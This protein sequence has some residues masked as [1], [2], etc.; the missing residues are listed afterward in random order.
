[1]SSC[2]LKEKNSNLKKKMKRH[3]PYP[4]S[5]RFSCQL[6]STRFSHL[7]SNIIAQWRREKKLNCVPEKITNNTTKRIYKLNQLNLAHTQ[8]IENI[9]RSV[10]RMIGCYH[11]WVFFT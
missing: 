11:G 5:I 10:S 2:E 9:S 7:I 8:K 1:M 4:R 6:I 3:Q